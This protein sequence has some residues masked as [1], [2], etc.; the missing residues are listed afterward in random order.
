MIESRAR[1]DVRREEAK[2]HWLCN[3]V[4]LWWHRLL[5]YCHSTVH[6]STLD[7][8]NFPEEE[9]NVLSFALLYKYRSIYTL[10]GYL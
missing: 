10:C 5:L 6:K 7:I 8:M 1:P 2:G 3:A 4:I 9:T